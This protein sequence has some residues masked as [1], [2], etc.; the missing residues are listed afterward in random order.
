VYS[1]T[2]EIFQDTHMWGASRGHLWGG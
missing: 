2:L 1:G